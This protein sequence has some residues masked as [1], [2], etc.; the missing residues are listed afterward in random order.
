MLINL[1]LKLPAEA[2][3]K[4]KSKLKFEIGLIL[5]LNLMLC[6]Y[7][8]VM[9]R[10]SGYDGDSFLVLQGGEVTQWLDERKS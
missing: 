2:G 3:N 9:S 1:S 5:V 8:L 6:Y 7:P 10:V 4:Y